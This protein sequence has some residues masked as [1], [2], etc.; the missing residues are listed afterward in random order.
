MDESERQAVL[1]GTAKKVFRVR[2]DCWC[3]A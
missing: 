2:P 3:K 1:E